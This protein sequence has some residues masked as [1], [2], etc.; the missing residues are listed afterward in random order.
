MGDA[1]SSLKPI[2]VGNRILGTLF[3][4]AFFGMGSVFC[5]LILREVYQTALTYGWKKTDCVI[6]ES[7]VRDDSRHQGT[8]YTF[9]VHFEYSWQGQL[10]MS[11]KWALKARSFSNYGDAQRLVDAYSVD[12]KGVCYVNPAD[13]T[14]AILRRGNFWIGLMVLLPLLFVAIGAG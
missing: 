13:P 8:P 12:T 3:F 6:L 2:G 5:G 9:T 4:L 10:H 7:A 1:S 14:M 11:D